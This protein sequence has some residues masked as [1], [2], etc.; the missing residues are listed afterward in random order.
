MRDQVYCRKGEDLH[1][2]L[3]AY[4]HCPIFGSLNILIIKTGN[5]FGDT[6]TGEPSSLHCGP[7]GEG[8]G[9]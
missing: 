8:K 2:V 6:I 1:R 5:I 4:H 9:R 3:H 7:G